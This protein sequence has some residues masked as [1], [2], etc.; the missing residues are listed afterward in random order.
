M[1]QCKRKR[2]R[3]WNRGSSKNKDDKLKGKLKGEIRDDNGRF[4]I[5]KRNKT[6]YWKATERKRRS[7]EYFE[8]VKNAKN[9]RVTFMWI[10]EDDKRVYEQEIKSEEVVYEWMGIWSVG[11]NQV[12]AEYQ[13][14]S[15]NTKQLQSTGCI[16][17]IS[18][19][20]WRGTCLDKCDGKWKG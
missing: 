4:E 7:I 16:W 10:K 13:P 8:K 3:W 17:G 20:G 1:E 15:W 19:L 5:K 2:G 14:R 11:G 6:W 12:L 9:Q 18:L